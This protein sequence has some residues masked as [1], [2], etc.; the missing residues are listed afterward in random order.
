VDISDHPLFDSGRLDGTYGRQD[1]K[2]KSDY[3]LLSSDLF[4]K[5]T[6]GGVC[7]L[8]VWD[9][10]KSAPTRWQIFGPPTVHLEM[11]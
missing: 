6:S 8:G 1:V 10:N 4:A 3:V 5:V 9:K 11:Q 7:R 2:Q